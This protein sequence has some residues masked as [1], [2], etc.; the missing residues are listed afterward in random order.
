MML[1][2]IA[3]TLMLYSL[4]TSEAAGIAELR[5]HYGRRDPNFWH[6]LMKNSNYTTKQRKGFELN[7]G[8]E[9]WD[10]KCQVVSH[11]ETLGDFCFIIQ[12]SCR[13][14]EDHRSKIL[15]S[16]KDDIFEILHSTQS[17][18]FSLVTY[19]KDATVILPCSTEVGNIEDVWRESVESVCDDHTAVTYKAI[20]ACHEL[21]KNKVHNGVPDNTIIFTD[22]ISK[23]D[24]FTIRN[25]RDK[26]ILAALKMKKENTMSI[27]VVKILPINNAVAITGDEEWN[28]LPHH[29]V[30]QFNVPSVPFLHLG[31]NND[32]TI[33]IGL[34]E[35]YRTD[36]T[37]PPC[38]TADV[39]FILDRSNSILPKNVDHLLEFLDD[40]L[41]AQ[42]KIVEPNMIDKSE[43]LQIALLT[44]GGGVTIHSKLG[45]HGKDDLIKIVNE[46]PRTTTKY[47]ST[48]IAL[49]MALKQFKTSNRKQYDH[50]RK[51]VVLAT[52]GRTWKVKKKRVDSGASTIKAALKLKKYGAEVYIIG[53]PNHNDK[54][55]G[56]EREWKHMASRPINC[57]IVDM[58]RPSEGGVFEDLKWVGIHLTEEICINNKKKSC[59]WGI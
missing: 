1:L 57:T 53:L 26:T 24:G 48:H 40:F 30:T 35:I 51:I 5:N 47:T 6:L 32:Q 22:G 39:V 49:K 25:A 16:V 27:Q 38:C 46:I 12:T 44:Y 9:Y 18:T 31:I 20:E 2:L 3:T 21:F 15:K 13:E 50:V 42:D 17:P 19:S 54:N 11:K 59:R 37:I 41:D 10:N 7:L 34:L 52:D 36:K 45:Q 29:V 55:D 14:N 56:Y 4:P 43:G 23:E 58:Q 33:K 8:P 28:I